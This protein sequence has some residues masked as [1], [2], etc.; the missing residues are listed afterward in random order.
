MSC[1]QGHQISKSEK[2]VRGDKPMNKRTVAEK[3][4]ENPLFGE[5][6]FKDRW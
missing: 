5:V 6:T 3:H 4:A 1:E 2:G